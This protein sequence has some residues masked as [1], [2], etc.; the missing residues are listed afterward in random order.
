MLKLKQKLESNV[1]DFDKQLQNRTHTLEEEK[2]NSLNK[3]QIQH[4]EAIK[5]ADARNQKKINHVK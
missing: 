3:L 1:T 4:E 5:R 2:N